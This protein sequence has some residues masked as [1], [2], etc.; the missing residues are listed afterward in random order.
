MLFDL[1]LV[2]GSCC[3]PVLLTRYFPPPAR[4]ITQDTHPPFQ[5][6]LFNASFQFNK[7]RCRVS[8]VVKTGDL[9]AFLNY[10]AVFK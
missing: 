2:R 5:L 1:L 9:S 7:L 4:N 3:L 6:F 10:T 8:A